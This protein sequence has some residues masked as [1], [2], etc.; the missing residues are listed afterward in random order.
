[1]STVNTLDTRPEDQRSNDEINRASRTNE[2]P[3]TRHMRSAINAFKMETES[4]FHKLSTDIS[5]L[6]RSTASINN[7]TE[8]LQ[9][10]EGLQEQLR[11][12]RNSFHNFNFG[13]DESVEPVPVT[14]RSDVV[15]R[16]VYDNDP[17][18][19]AEEEH[20]EVNASHRAR[21]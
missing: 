10:F 14:R 2:L 1:M 11:N 13:A 4:A 12:I 9:A 18:K 7:P 3:A 8:R 16:T 5:N 6:G 17:L 21:R 15:N 19:T 20:A